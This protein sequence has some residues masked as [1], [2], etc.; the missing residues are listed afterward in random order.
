MTISKGE[1]L[2]ALHARAA[3]I[4]LVP[5]FEFHPT[6]KW[7]ADFAFPDKHLLIEIDGGNRKACIGKDGKA[8][9][10]G[11]HTKDADM[12]KLNEAA[13]LGYFVLRF[14]PK[15]VKSG[16]ALQV[17]ERFLNHG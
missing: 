3:G 9:A 11:R 2:F 12:G 6:R 10:V 5:E 15:M 7:R 14:T 17:L 8:Y 16:E 13:L 1:A 4:K